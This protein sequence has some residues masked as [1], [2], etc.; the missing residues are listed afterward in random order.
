MKLSKAYKKITVRR[1]IVGCRT[2][3]SPLNSPFN[4]TTKSNFV[5]KLLLMGIIYYF[6]AFFGMFRHFPCL[7]LKFQYWFYLQV[8]FHSCGAIKQTSLQKSSSNDLD[9]FNK[10]K[11]VVMPILLIN[12]RLCVLSPG[13]IA[14]QLFL[15]FD[16]FDR[17]FDLFYL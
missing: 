2:L 7:R 6:G 16:L 10:L 4:I 9:Y 5:S 17:S 3:F 1:I 14:F 11:G 15:I 13:N 12:D 8:V